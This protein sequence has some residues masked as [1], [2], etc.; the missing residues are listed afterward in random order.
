[1]L[2]RGV[3]VQELLAECK[4]SKYFRVF[5]DNE[6]TADALPLLTEDELA[7]M[8]IPLGARKRILMIG[9]ERTSFSAPPA[10]GSPSMSMH[11]STPS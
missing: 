4:L 1:V 7:D 2:S 3:I 8:G 11:P 9:A 10:D 6:V 5:R